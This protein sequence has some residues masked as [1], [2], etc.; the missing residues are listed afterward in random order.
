MVRLVII[1]IASSSSSGEPKVI[2]S[3]LLTASFSRGI[4]DQF[5]CAASELES[6]GLMQVDWGW[7]P[8]F[9]SRSFLIPN[10]TPVQSDSAQHSTIDGGFV[11]LVVDLGV[12][13]DRLTYGTRK[14]W[15]DVCRGNKSIVIRDSNS[16]RRAKESKAAR[17]NSPKKKSSRKTRESKRLNSPRRLIVR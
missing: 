13:D 5:V 10:H 8:N 12:L 2:A 4:Y 9:K 14:A 15:M 17:K 16:G 3:R 1:D 7:T 11:W 6:L